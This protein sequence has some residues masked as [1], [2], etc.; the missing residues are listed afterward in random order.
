M[1]PPFF[2]DSSARDQVQRDAPNLLWLWRLA[3][4]DRV[5]LGSPHGPVHALKQQ[6]CRGLQHPEAAWRFVLRHGRA[7][8]QAILSHRDIRHKFASVAQYSDAIVEMGLHDPLPPPVIQT[9]LTN[10]YLYYN[11]RIPF[12]WADYVTR[13]EVAVRALLRVWPRLSTS[14]RK[15]LIADGFRL[16]LQWIAWAHPKLDGNSR[17]L[18]WGRILSR[19]RAWSDRGRAAAH[20]GWAFRAPTSA[21]C[22]F[23]LVA[24]NSRLSLFDE[25][26]VMRSC[27]YSLADLCDSGKSRFFGLRANGRR[28]ATIELQ[29]DGIN[30]VLR[31]CRGPMNALPSE[32]LLRAARNLVV[33]ADLA[34]IP[35]R[36]AA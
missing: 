4:H 7:G 21:C 3:R 34:D 30:W 28:V 35:E 12:F 25:G 5:G 11:S 13:Y 17:R 1:S 33:L 8:V 31:D 18:S 27:V 22:G 10:S 23:E 9:L 2:P 15:R 24:L 32:P 20:G 16:V 19:A 36:E 6:F 29:R 26:V 14:Q